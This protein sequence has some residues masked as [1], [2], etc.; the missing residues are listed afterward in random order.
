[1][2][3]V[4]FREN[5]EPGDVLHME[6][7]PVPEPG[8]ARI[9]VAVHACGLNPADWPGCPSAGASGF[10]IMDHWFTV[11]A[12]LDL[13]QAAALP[14][15]LDTAYWHLMRLGLSADQTIL[16]HGAGSMVG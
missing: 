2:R 15:P 3:T 1:M 8:P 4:R 13:T 7:A 10:A 16:I 9:R 14:M 5:G 12:G 11:P 6:T